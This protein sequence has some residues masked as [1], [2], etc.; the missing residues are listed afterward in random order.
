MLVIYYIFHKNTVKKTV[1]FQACTFF[2]ATFNSFIFV[3]GIYFLV[4][5]CVRCV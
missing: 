4:I 1:Q 5:S 3:N 2:R